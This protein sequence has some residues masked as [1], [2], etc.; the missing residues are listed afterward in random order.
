MSEEPEH[1]DDEPKLGDWKMLNQLVAEW[2]ALESIENEANEA[3]ARPSG[4]RPLTSNF[5]YGVEGSWTTKPKKRK[6]K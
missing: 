5:D 6:K 3:P 2:D 1:E 4:W